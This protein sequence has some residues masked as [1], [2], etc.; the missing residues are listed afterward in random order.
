MDL[1]PENNQKLLALAEDNHHEPKPQKERTK[2]KIIGCLWNQKIGTS[3]E[4]LERKKKGLEVKAT[5]EVRNK[6][7]C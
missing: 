5:Q 1:P 4:K 7:Q 6:T 3:I 2:E